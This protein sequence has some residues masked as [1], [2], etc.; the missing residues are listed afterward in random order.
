LQYPHDGSVAGAIFPTKAAGILLASEVH[1]KGRHYMLWILAVLMG[2][3]GVG[4]VTVRRKRKAEHKPAAA[5]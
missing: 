2:G 3:L 5:R 4:Y 1:F